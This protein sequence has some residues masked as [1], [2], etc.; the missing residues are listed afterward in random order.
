MAKHTIHEADDAWDERTLGADEDFVAVADDDTERRVDAAAGMQMI[1]IRLRKSMIDDFKLLA[2]INKGIG[3]QTLMRQVLQRFVDCEMKRIAR[4][5]MS[6]KV[7]RETAHDNGEVP[8]KR[9]QRKA[10]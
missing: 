1:S 4:E 3:Y 6:E 9:K 2:S 7:V 5:L 8:S 10:A